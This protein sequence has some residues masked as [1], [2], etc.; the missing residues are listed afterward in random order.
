MSEL[1]QIEPLDKR[2]VCQ[3]R[4]R[5]ATTSPQ[6]LDHLPAEWREL[7]TRW[8][9]RGGNSRWET[10]R[11]DAGSNRVQMAQS[12]LDWLLSAGWAAVVE[13]RKLSEWWP[14]QVELRHMSQLR[15]TLGV[16][17]KDDEAQRWQV[18]R[19]S[20]H[21]LN[22]A[23][24]LPAIMALDEI[25]V[26]RA[27]ARQELIFKLNEWQNLQQSG[28]RR[29]FALFARRDTKAV[30]EA[31]WN[32]LE[33]V[34][35][36]SAFNIERHTPLLLLSAPLVLEFKHGSMNLAA[37][38]DFAALTPAS[39]QGLRAAAGAV[40]YW[41]LVENRTSFERLAR[42]REAN[43]GIIWLP[44]FPP[45]WWRLA[46]GRL[47]DLAPAPARI[48]CDP[49]P[50][51][52]AIALQ[53]ATIWRQRQLAWQA[54]QMDAENL[55]ALPARKPISD[56]DRQLIERLLNEQELPA[57]LAQL[58]HWMLEHGEKGEQEGYL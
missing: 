56:T 13:Q 34:L 52:I 33:T 36:L 53:A 11:N 26:S 51:G 18:I 12:L 24:L 54:W 45:T 19:S 30:S 3:K 23:A 5:M 40:S 57:S 25:P 8:V 14:Q 15:A 2:A 39:L 22:N 46:V 10:L 20:L 58:A 35:D 38:P 49:D 50:S 47:L 27:L 17:D 55:A 9:K 4:R 43:A 21:A 31:D 6:A 41:H 48:S 42:Q 29:D 1:W 28:T 16:P 7:L 44:G 32:W 37:C